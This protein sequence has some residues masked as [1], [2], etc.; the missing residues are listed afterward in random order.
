MTPSN[1]AGQFT[2]AHRRSREIRADRLA[3]AQNGVLSRAQLAEIGVPRWQIRSN[4]RAGRWRPHGRHC[5]AVHSGELTGS[6]R[7]WHA[8]FET[9]G[10][11][12]L[13]GVT[14]LE[15]AGLRGFEGSL[16]V[17]VPKSSKH[18]RPRGVV[19]HETRRLLPGDVLTNGPRRLRP[20][21]AAVFGALWALSLRQAALVLVMTVNQRLATVEQVGEVWTRV[22]RHRWRRPLTAVLADL[23]D[24]V[25]S[26]G[27]LDFARLCRQYGLPEPQRQVVR[28]GPHGRIYLDVRWDRWSLVVEIDGIAHDAPAAWVPDA[29]R[30]NHVTLGDDRVLRIPV[31]GLRIA[32]AEFM[33]QVAD[34]LRLAG[35]PLPRRTA[36]CSPPFF[37]TSVRMSAMATKATDATAVSAQRPY[38]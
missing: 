25:R 4:V 3:D 20:E 24:G 12:A 5:V 28:R 35:C 17:V 6:A 18:H 7:W 33:A 26:M 10:G 14:A 34:G 11:A 22:R 38:S 15:Y 23:S 37:A 2:D 9:G 13:G 36:A 31:L 32:E 8:V 27:E 19:V 29:L 16:H 21:V 1:V 30:Q